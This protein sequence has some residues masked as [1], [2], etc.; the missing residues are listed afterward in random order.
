MKLRLLAMATVAAAAFSTPALAGDGWYLG[1]GGGWDN[2]VGYN[3]KSVGTPSVIGKTNAKDSAIGAIATMKS[4][5]T[6]HQRNGSTSASRKATGILR[7][8]GA[9]PGSTD[10][11][12]Q[13]A[14]IQLNLSG[15]DSTL[16]ALV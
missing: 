4:V 15:T 2:Q 6:Y 9:R 12:R 11:I 8:G 13:N 10:P 14:S 1:L 16:T 7:G 3:V 5:H